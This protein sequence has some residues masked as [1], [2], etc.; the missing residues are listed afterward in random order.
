MNEISTRTAEVI[1]GEINQIKAEVRD[2]V[3]RA[4]IEIGKRLKEAKALVPYGQWGDWLAENVDYS[5]RTAQNYMAIA[6]EYGQ[7]ETQALAQ[8]RSKEQAILLL[9]LDEREREAFVQQHD[10]GAMSTR[11]LKEELERVK[12]ERDRLQLTMDEMLG[13]AQD[14]QDMPD[15]EAAL[16]LAPAEEIEAARAELNAER[17]KLEEKWQEMEAAMR[18]AQA[19]KNQ[20]DKAR[21]RAGDLEKSLMEARKQVDE[22]EKRRQLE[23]K[24]EKDARKKAQEQHDQQMKEAQEQLDALRAQLEAAKA[25][26]KTVEVVPEAVEKELEALRA[27]AAR[28]GVEQELHSLFAIFRQDFSRLVDKLEEAEESGQSDLAAKYRAAF[29]KATA[30]MA[31]RLDVEATRPAGALNKVSE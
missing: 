15:A 8:I 9:A 27:K 2:T 4:A 30:V 10:L 22:T 3:I 20:A 25:E 6:D 28:D 19:A 31:G 11:E 21:E 18:E 13:H 12:A 29:A 14:G 26:V 5:E 7:K 23:T 16:V 24:Q 17:D 1:A